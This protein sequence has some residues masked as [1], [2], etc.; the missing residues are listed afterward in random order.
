MVWAAAPVLSGGWLALVF[1][2]GFVPA[3]VVY[4]TK[5]LVDGVNAAVGAGLTREAVLE[6][7]VPA[8]VMGGLILLQQI[9]GSLVGYIQTAQ[10]EQ[11][12]DVIK[13]QIHAKAVEVDYAFYESDDYHNKLQDAHAQASSR[14]LGLLQ[15]VG[16]LLQNSIAFLS[17]AAIIASYALWLPIALFAGAAPGVIVLI[18]HNQ[19][20]RD[21]WDRTMVDR[22][23]AQWLDYIIIF[24]EYVAESRLYGFGTA[25]AA[26]YQI[27]RK[28]LR[29]ARLRLMRRQSVARLGSGMLTLVGVG[30]IMGWMVVRALRG[31]ATLGDLALFYQAVNQGQ[32]ITQSLLDGVGNA[33]SNALFLEQLFSFLDLEPELKDPDRPLPEPSTIHQGIT[34]EDVSF[35]YPGASRP[36][37]RGLNLHLPAGKVTAIVGVNGAGKSTLIKLLCRFYD[38]DS[39]HVR[40]DGHDIRQFARAD[41]QRNVNVLFQQPVQHQDT[42]RSNISLSDLSASDEEIQAAAR[43]AGA[44]DFIERL[45]RGYDSTLGRLFYEAAELSGGQWQRVALARAYLRPAPVVILDEPTSAMD[46][47]SE[48]DWFRR[49]RTLV[50]GRTAVVITHR[51][52]VAMQA[53]VIHV[54]ED[55]RVIESGSH[56]DLLAQ[57][58]RYAES[59]R[60]QTRRA[61]EAGG[62]E[63]GDGAAAPAPARP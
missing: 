25:L 14:A 10:G 45:P 17:I 62:A 19:R 8:L 12:Q 9:L 22:R 54:M 28:D 5:W 11:V 63:A 35:T 29:E 59:W 49:L 26:Q 38:V 7:L 48:M 4:T 57:N 27:L 30:S 56:R 34:F 55:G 32:S 39:G 60:E 41:V 21:W 2:Q 3:G 37:L 23:R 31:A 33:Y 46:S 6:A 42:A 36:S 24:P 40:I 13:A 1:L 20:Y 58:G 43:A 52:T 53:D 61:E 15:N 51:F 18:R 44:H 16:S 47:W 50:E